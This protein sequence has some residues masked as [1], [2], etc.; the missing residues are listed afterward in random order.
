LTV[1]PITF[2]VASD[3]FSLLPACCIHYPVGEKA[4]L[5]EWVAAVAETKNAYTILMGDSLDAARTHYRNHI[6]GYRD[7]SNSQESLDD[8][9]KRVIGELA[10]ILKPIRKRIIGAIRGNHYWEFNDAT[11]SE[12]YLCQ[13]LEVPYLGTL[14]AIRVVTPSSKE[15]TIFAHHSGGGGGMTVGGDA[16]A[17]LKQESA[18]DADVYLMGHTHKRLAFKLPTMKLSSEEKPVIVERSRVF[19]RCGA[20]LKGF[21]PDFPTTSQPHFPSYAEEKAY[22]PTDLG[23]VRVDVEWR[24]DGYPS[25]EV[26]Y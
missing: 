2:R 19:V 21:K 12:Q 23:W 10:E 15:L 22:R 7:D 9:Q 24:K 4:L 14:S 20:F 16:N 3:R 6:R 5:K 17:M 13:L 8:L 1:N 26:R 18:W 25:F 11:N